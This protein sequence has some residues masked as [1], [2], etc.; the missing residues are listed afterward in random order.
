MLVHWLNVQ[1]DGVLY[2]IKFMCLENMV[3]LVLEQR[4]FASTSD[5]PSHSQVH[6][7]LLWL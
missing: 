7:Q 2:F 5:C 3:P 4:T 1:A 6:M